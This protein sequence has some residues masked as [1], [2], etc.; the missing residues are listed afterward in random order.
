MRIAIARATKALTVESGDNKEDP[1]P[2]ILR[3]EAGSRAVVSFCLL[4]GREQL[5]WT[6]S[7]IINR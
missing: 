3:G 4:L 1:R 2:V 5:F 6:R 7:T